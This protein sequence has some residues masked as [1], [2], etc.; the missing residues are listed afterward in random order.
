[1][2]ETSV[3]VTVFKV[4]YISD[5]E[6]V[7]SSHCIRT[8][9]PYS[10]RFNARV[11]LT[12]GETLTV[13][14]K[15]SIRI[16]T[17]PGVTHKEYVIDV[18]KVEKL[19]GTGVHVTKLLEHNIKGVGDIKAKKLWTQ[20][21]GKLLEMV[22]AGDKDSLLKIIPNDKI[23]DDVISFLK[24][25]LNLLSLRELVGLSIN[26]SIFKKAV[27]A[28]G[29]DA[30]LK[31]KQDPYRLMTFG[32]S[33]PNVDVLARVKF[34]VKDDD[35]RRLHAVMVR[36]L[37][38]FF[39]QK[40][41]TVVPKEY[42]YDRVVKDLKAELAKKAFSAPLPGIV[43]NDDSYALS[44]VRYM[45][46]EVEK[47]LDSRI[48]NNFYGLSESNK[49]DCL[50]SI[51]FYEELKGFELTS[52]QIVAVLTCCGASTALISG[53]AGCG[54]TTVL[55]SL[56]GALKR[57]NGELNIHQIALSGK[58]ARRMQEA[59]GIEARTIASF[60]KNV[61]LEKLGLNDLV[62]IDEC[63]MVD[64]ATAY[65]LFRRLKVNVRV[66]LVGDVMQLPP[67]TAGLFFHKLVGGKLPQASLN[68][69]KRQ[70]EGSEIISL[71]SKV[72]AG[73]DVSPS[74]YKNIIF[75]D[76]SESI[77]QI[78]EH[79]GGDYKSFNTVFCCPVKGKYGTD[80]I[81]HILI[82]EKRK[83]G[84]RGKPVQYANAEG[85][86]V[87]YNVYKG[88]VD[89]MD[90]SNLCVGDLV[91]NTEN[92]YDLD[93][94]NGM[95]GIVS[96]LSTDPSDEYICTISFDGIDVKFRL[97]DLEALVFAYAMT[98]HKLQGSQFN[99]VI[100]SCDKPPLPG[101]KKNLI[102]QQMLY[103]GITR[104]SHKLALIGFEGYGEEE[105]RYVGLD[106]S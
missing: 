49:A 12:L 4:R 22:K 54:K 66:I 67:V 13:S 102:S 38:Y 40:K 89:T 60:L 61:E 75:F 62:V 92:N 98:I 80:R 35:S 30:Y 106:L 58:A 82:T 77:V 57:L 84:L 44:G 99:N 76:S 32:M 83:L 97:Q 86:L 33:F 34:F 42:L 64:L 8:Q 18:D 14:G 91:L 79:M 17:L 55:E 19:F 39:S 3:T 90:A 59:T 71:A 46:R 48:K 69:I 26:P 1:M 36:E 29:D 25:H 27:S 23:I 100:V 88:V 65:Y 37:E 103:T 85:Y 45:E 2:A 20:T 81:N 95:V 21:G 41:W 52:E 50:A 94:M 7:Y 78:Y 72:R 47:S 104:A 15:S 96:G 93:V 73:L 43:S 87:N 10:I 63:S 24:S 74:D 16:N 11:A 53:A 56:Y 68:T 51:K 28:W 101:G 9:K 70:A 105:V 31:I 5:K 6:S